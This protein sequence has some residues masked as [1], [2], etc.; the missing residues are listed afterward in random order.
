MKKYKIFHADCFDWLAEQPENTIN[1]ICTDPPYGLVEFSRK[2]LDKLRRGKGGTWRIPPK[3]GGIRR[4]PLP[5]FTTLNARQ[6]AHL[7]AYFQ[8]WGR[9]LM[10]PLLPGSH[11][12]VAGTPALQYLVQSAMADAGFEVR[13]AILRLYNGFRGGDR[14]KNAEKEYPAVCVTPKS[15][16]EPWMLFRKPISEKTVAQNLRKWGT[17]GLRRLN[18]DKPFPEVIQSQRTPKIEKEIANH[19]CLKPQKYMRLMVRSLLPLG[20]GVVADPFMGAGSAIAAANAV[21]YASLGI[22]TD[23]EYF[24]MA[25]SAIP[26]LAALYPDFKGNH[27]EDLQKVPKPK[28]VR[29]TRS[30]DRQLVLPC[31]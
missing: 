8:E 15:A 30:A 29:Q 16:Y 6:K 13:P 4:D 22:E 25:A 19:P 21:G 18:T 31:R 10:K 5:R 28:N 14:P 24:K 23:D 2:E 9:L 11:I 27:I 20:E 12:C 1:A 3:I 26:L 17:G 7:T